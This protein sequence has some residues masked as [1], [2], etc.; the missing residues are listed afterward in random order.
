LLT[1]QVGFCPVTMPYEDLNALIG[2]Q[3]TS[4]NP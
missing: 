2:Y 1:L 4:Y 3:V